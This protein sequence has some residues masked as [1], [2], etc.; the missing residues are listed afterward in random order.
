[1]KIY[2]QKVNCCN[3]KLF[4]KTLK[5]TLF[6]TGN[7]VESVAL[8][9]K[10]VKA[11]EIQALN[12]EFRGVDKVTDVLSFPMLNIDYKGDKLS[13][14]DDDRNPNGELYLG[15]IVVCKEKAK[16]QA[17]EYGHSFKR[18]IS[19]LVVHGYLHLL[20]YDHI[21]K[22]DE[23]IMMSVAENILLNFNIKRRK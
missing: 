21:E 10:F 14:F 20:G 13:A 4:L 18:E 17:K 19:F 7:N 2:T 15:D 12:K 1:M 22:T 8:G 9:I 3:K 6:I 5:K 11:E 16:E 23:E